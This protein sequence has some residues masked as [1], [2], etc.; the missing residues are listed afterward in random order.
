MFIIF[1]LS[2][3]YLLLS[4]LM[5]LQGKI[6]NVQCLIGGVRRSASSLAG[7]SKILDSVAGFTKP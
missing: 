5:I 6:S 7:N 2:S 4:P 1:F 3:F